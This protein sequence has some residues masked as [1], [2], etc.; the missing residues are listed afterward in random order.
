[1]AMIIESIGILLNRWQGSSLQS[2]GKVSQQDMP[3]IQSWTSKNYRGIW[4]QVLASTK[5]LPMNVVKDVA[6]RE[7]ATIMVWI[8]LNPM[9]D[10]EILGALFLKDPQQMW[11][12][13]KVQINKCSDKST[14]STVGWA[15]LALLNTSVL[16]MITDIE[17]IASKGEMYY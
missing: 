14:L 13:L 9:L 3:C 10:I 11:I 8:Q 5:R 4:Y 7:L 6:L 16:N 1:M 2:F 15:Q 12:V 17:C